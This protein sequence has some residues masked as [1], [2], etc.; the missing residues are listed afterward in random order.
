MTTDKFSILIIDDDTNLRRT[1]ADILSVKGYQTLAAKD[2]SEGLALL[3]LHTVHLALVDLRLPDMSGLEIL[4]IIRADHPH[5]EVII[6]TGN[7][8]LD[9]AIEATN[10]GA[11]SYLQKPYDIDQLMLHIKRSIEKQ[12]AEEKIRQYQGHLEELVRERTCELETAMEAAEAGNRAKTEFIANMSHEI[13]TPLNAIIGFS[14]VLRDGILGLLNKEQTEYMNDIVR[15]GRHLL[16]LILN[17]LAVAE[18]ESDRMKLRSDKIRLKDIFVSALSL[19]R[20]EAMRKDILTDYKISAEADIDIEADGSRLQQ[21]MVSLLDNAVKFTPAG[22]SVKVTA[23]RMPGDWRSE[24]GRD[25]TDIKTRIANPDTDLIEISVADTGIG[26][27]PEDILKLFRPFQQLEAPYTKRYRGTGLGLLLAKKLIE[28]H[29]GKIRVE[30]EF[31][32]GSTF[33]FVIPV[34]QTCDNRARTVIEDKK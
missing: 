26:I 20:D 7:A 9:S 28:L 22:G 8:T 17:V 30:S 10:K 13:R 29:G 23:R 32:K 5:T 6:L 19:V 27:K 31:G 14:E 15:N 4:K 11:F 1:L 25:D 18:A 16:E 3:G 33:T 12:Q 2:G 21:V 34:K 24:T